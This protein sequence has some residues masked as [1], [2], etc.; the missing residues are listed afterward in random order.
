MRVG[1]PWSRGDLIVRREVLNDGRA[2][3]EMEVR[4]VVD[5]DDLLATYMATGAS[6]TFPPG[7]WPIA[8]GLHPWH[9]KERWR[10]NGVLMLQ[11]PGDAYAIWVFW[12]GPERDFRGWYVNL[13]DAFRRTERGYDTQDHELDIWVPVDGPWQW[14]DDE[15][16]E[17]RVDEGRFTT[18]QAEQFRAEGR[19]IGALI[20][21]GEQWW[22]DAWSEWA[23]DP[24]W[25]AADERG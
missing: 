5:N 11:R 2:W 10:G 18:A 9:A 4:V 7:E 21:A 15:L 19:R 1:D 8:G 13:Q 20:D 23:P 6:F 22:D 17:V 16:L 25:D 12:F 24:G 14:K 3:A